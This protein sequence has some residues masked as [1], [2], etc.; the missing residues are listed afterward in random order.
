MTGEWLSTVIGSLI[1]NLQDK[2]EGRAERSSCP[3]R[4]M[5]LSEDS[6]ETDVSLIVSITRHTHTQTHTHTQSHTYFFPDT[7][8]NTTTPCTIKNTR[9]SSSKQKSC[10]LIYLQVMRNTLD[11]V[12][13]C[14]SVIMN[15]KLKINV[16]DLY[17][18]HND[19]KRKTTL[20]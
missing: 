3:G 10:H 9:T 14:I 5:L 19:E 8:T 6:E 1:R 4:M 2:G 20:K 17:S 15:L 16:D 7:Y 18:R 12:D 11:L 13:I